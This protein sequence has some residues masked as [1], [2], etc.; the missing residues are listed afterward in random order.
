M[1]EF[2]FQR[3]FGFDGYGMLGR[4]FDFFPSFGFLLR[5]VFWGLIVWAIYVFITRSGWR[6]TRTTP[7][8]ES[9]PSPPT[10]LENKE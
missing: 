6:L 3:G 7:A 4:G 5:L 2:G 10:T 1:H 8:S 9:P